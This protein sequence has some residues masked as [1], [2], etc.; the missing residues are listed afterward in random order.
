MMLFHLEVSVTISLFGFVNM[1][2]DI[3]SGFEYS[4]NYE[5]RDVLSY[6]SSRL[7]LGI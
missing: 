4:I 5:N 1:N 3:L 2:M 6:N 7:R